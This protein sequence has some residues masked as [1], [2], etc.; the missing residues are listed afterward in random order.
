MRCIVQYSGGAA[1]AL[2]AQ[3][4]VE[5]FGRENVVLL[6][7]DTLMEDEDLYRFNADVE[8]KLGI[9]ITRLCEGRTPWEV[10]FSERMIGN[11]RADH[12]SRILKREVL[13]AWRIANTTPENDVIFLGM[14]ANEEHR[15]KGV[16]ARLSPWTVRSPLIERGIWKERALELVKASGLRLSRSYDQGA[17]HDNCGGFCIKAGQGQ[18]VRLLETRAARYA[19][20]EG[21]EEAFRRFTGKDV[22]I[23]RDRTGGKTK[24]LTL[25]QLRERHE[26]QPS[27]I[28]R[29]DIGGCNC[30]VPP[31]G[32]NA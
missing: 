30:M 22:S 13:D 23:L 9:K 8:R 14:D 3:F 25:R 29:L 27:L 1:S 2:S 24:P 32:E 10:F 11:S 18:F 16:Q 7:A 17:P 28:D 21:K 20:H 6:F 5:E 12:C 4:A 19:L 26:Q 31:E 15:L